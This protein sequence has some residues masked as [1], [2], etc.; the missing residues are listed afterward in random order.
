MTTGA[1]PPT[2]C[3]LRLPAPR[4][5]TPLPQT[6]P[7]PSPVLSCGVVGN[8]IGAGNH[9]FFAAF[10]LA[11]QAGGGVMAA[12]AAWRLRR[13]GFPGS[14]AAAAQGETWLILFTCVVGAYHA[15]AMLFGTMHCLGVMLSEWP[16]RAW[17][18]AGRLGRPSGR[19]GRPSGRL[20][21]PSGRLG[22]PSGR[23]GRPSP[24]HQ[25]WCGGAATRGEQGWAS[26]PAAL[27]A[28]PGWRPV[29][30][31]STPPIA[32]LP[33]RHHHQGPPAGL[34]ALRQ[35]PLLP[36][37]PQPHSADGRPLGHL[38]RTAAAAA[39]AVA[40]RWRHQQWQRRWRRARRHGAAGRAGAGQPAG[41]RQARSPSRVGAWP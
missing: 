3:A 33:P 26:V 18:T 4:P 28:G 32:N 41:R 35:P 36:R 11:A 29:T 14:A 20:G 5:A 12:G 8:C 16:G 27:I 39:T 6:H 22:R 30:W 13:R 2:S 15:L 24:R 19:L 37:R 40:H 25:P 21:R 17:G 7:P 38:L 9:R 31:P 10:L 1:L 23:L 34:Q